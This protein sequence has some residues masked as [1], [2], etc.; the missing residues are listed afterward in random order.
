[1]DAE[2]PKTLGYAKVLEAEQ[3]A[4]K[5]SKVITI[6]T[7]IDVVKSKAFNHE[8][9]GVEW[10]YFTSVNRFLMNGEELVSTWENGKRIKK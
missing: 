2:R 4:K 10:R 9:Q 8:T 3:Q 5:I 6:S 1:M 7:Q